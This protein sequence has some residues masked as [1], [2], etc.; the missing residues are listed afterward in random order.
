MQPGTREGAAKLAEDSL[1]FLASVD[2]LCGFAAA[3]LEAAGEQVGA[4]QALRTAGGLVGRH[5]L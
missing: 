3:F 2:K 5:A 4:L 1:A